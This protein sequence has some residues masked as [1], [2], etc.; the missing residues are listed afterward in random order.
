[1]ATTLGR[2]SADWNIML[3]SLMVIWGVSATFFL[4]VLLFSHPPGDTRTVLLCIDVIAFTVLGMLVVGQERLPRWTPDLCAYLMYVIVGGVIFTVHEGDSPI[5]FFYLW[6]SVHSFYFLPWRR[7]AP[8]VAF[9]AFNYA[10][11]LLAIPDQAFPLLRWAVTVLT[12]VVICTF[13]ALLRARVDALVARLSGAARTDPL[14]GLRNRRAY[15]EL[16]TVEVA[17]ADRTGHPLAL[18]V[19][20]I[21]HFKAI[22]DR[23]GHPTGDAVL[24]KVAAE[25]ERAERRIDVVAR[26]GGEEFVVLLPETDSDG[27]YLV[28]E[29]MRHAVHHAFGRDRFEVSISA[30]V[31]CYPDDAGDAESLFR[32]ADIALLAGKDA[33]RDCSVV[34]SGPRLQRSP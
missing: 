2:D 13:V 4:I 11:S 27:G 22:N 17:R 10:I 31:A 26:I 24:R 32:A 9:I 20:D 1:M 15:D 5:A 29:R 23:F 12:I 33:G 7:A 8:Q 19:I 18:L 21:D 30:G 25:L 3:R 14:T 6:L 16:M 28:A 34:Y